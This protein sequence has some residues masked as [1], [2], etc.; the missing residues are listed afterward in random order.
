MKV[1]VRLPVDL[2]WALA[3]AESVVFSLSDL[4]VA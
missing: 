2:S 3:M 4:G 1:G